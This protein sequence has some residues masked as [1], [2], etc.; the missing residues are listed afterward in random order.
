V[1]LHQPVDESTNAMRSA[2]VSGRVL[3]ATIRYSASSN[4]GQEIA[5][6]FRRPKRKVTSIEVSRPE[7]H[8][9]PSPCSA[10][11]SPK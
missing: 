9:S 5:C 6:F 1:V 2:S 8:T 4:R 10:W 11:P 3:P 7:P